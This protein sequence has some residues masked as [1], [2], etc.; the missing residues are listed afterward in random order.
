MEA[1]YKVL[2]DQIPA[3]VFMAYLDE[4]VGEAYVNPQIEK[5]LGFSQS[6]WLEDPVRWYRQIHPEDKA[7]WSV[8]CKWA[9]GCSSRE[10]LCDR[11]IELLGS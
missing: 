1:R 6:E 5:L 11:P 2:L 7:R 10:S 4:G 8:E 9:Q 3:V